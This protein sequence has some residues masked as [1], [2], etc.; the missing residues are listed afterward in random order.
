MTDR[1]MEHGRNLAGLAPSTYEATL[2]TTL[3][4]GYPTGS[5]MPLG[6]GH[7]LLGLRHRLALPAVPGV[8]GGAAR[9]HALRAARAR[10]RLALAAGERSRRS[11]RPSRRCCSATSLWGGIKEVAGAWLF[12]LRRGARALD[13]RRREAA[14]PCCRWRRPARRSSASLS[15]PAAVWLAP[16]FLAIAGARRVALD[17][18]SCFWQ[19]G[20]FAAGDRGARDPGLRR[21]RS[22]G[23]HASGG[24]RSGDELGNLIGPLSGLQLFGIWPIGDFRVRPHDMAPTYVLI[25]V[26]I[27]GRRSLGA[28]VGLAARRLGA[29][30]LRRDRRGRRRC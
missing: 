17:R 23:C 16:L 4:L 22:T 3:A 5:L 25:A 26:V 27:G 12:A 19:A 1:V 14:G 20:A 15:L 11:S 24:F 9:A 21:V 28:L 6:I 30:A 29:A 2:A 13:A 8:P 18:P 10:G 7:Q